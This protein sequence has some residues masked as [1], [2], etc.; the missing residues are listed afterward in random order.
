[1]R[2]FDVFVHGATPSGIFSAIVCA[3]AGKSVVIQAPE[4]SIGGMITGGLGIT[5]APHRFKNWAGG[6]VE[7]FTDAVSS[8]TGYNA[9]SFLQWN[10]PP[11]VAHRVLSRMIRAEP[12]IVLALGETITQVIRNEIVDQD[13]QPDSAVAERGT[14]IAAIATEGCSWLRKPGKGGLYAAKVYIDASYNGGLMA[15]ANVPWRIGREAASQFGED[16]AGANPG[17]VTE[18]TY[19]VVDEKGNLTKYGGWRAFEPKG[20]ADRR[21]MAMGFRNCITNIPGDSNLRFPA[22]PGFD[23]RDFSDE[24]RL[25]QKAGS[26]RINTREHAYRPIYRAT[27]DAEKAKLA[28]PNFL[29]LGEQERQNTWLRLSSI[30]EMTE[31]RDKFS[32]NGSDI[33]GEVSSEYS[34]ATDKRRH[35]IREFLAYRELGRLHIFQQRF[36]V[37]QVVRRNFSMWGLCADEWQDDYI[38]T[39][40][41]PSELYQREGRR[42]VGQVTINFWHAVYEVNWEDSIAVGQYILD[43][44]AKTQTARPFGGTK[45]EGHLAVKTFQ[46]AN[47][48]E[49][50][51]GNANYITVPLRAVVPPVGE[52]DNLIVSWGISASE[53]AFTAI[54]LEPFLSAVG[55]ACGHVALTSLEMEVSP[56]KLS[57]APVQNRLKKAGLTITRF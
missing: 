45:F 30:K 56:A 5:D 37:P 1:M 36:E 32:A 27:Y 16:Y 33:R 31:Y 3:R 39:P 21:S 24:V 35:E 6:V 29:Q 4:S 41:W 47:G 7:E 13:G 40:G 12:N 55:E 50:H 44:K 15:A 8:I 2:K 9:S 22:P 11:S 48:A 57:Y 17:C 42:L 25:A 14:R 49:V 52:C 34:E 38:L 46:D 20:S 51:A 54:R 18:R 23:I 26:I 28:I 19:D 43:S 10:F 53:V